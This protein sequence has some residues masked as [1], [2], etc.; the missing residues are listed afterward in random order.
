MG[1]KSEARQIGDVLVTVTQHPARRGFRLLARLGRLI[2][3]GLRAAG[4]ADSVIGLLLSA[5]ENLPDAEVE[6]LLL[7]LFANA[8]AEKDGKNFPLSQPNMIDVAFE[9]N[10]SGIVQSVR[11]AIEVNFGGFFLDS[12]LGDD[13][14]A[15]AE[16][17]SNS[18]TT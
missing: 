17:S 8:R 4:G 1:L 12:L 14:P 11:F 13:P 10:V 16:E 5:I 6:P 7:E 2:A 9:G 3:P 15:A 18:P